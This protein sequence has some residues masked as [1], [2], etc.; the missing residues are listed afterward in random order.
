VLTASGLCKTFGSLRVA[1]DITIEVP[2]GRR[3]AIIGPNGAGKTTFFNLLAG[4]VKA[5]AG[6]VVIDGI[7]VSGAPPDAR[8]RAG[9]GRSFQRSNLFPALSVRDNILM[10]LI[11]RHRLGHVAW[12]RLRRFAA[13]AEEAEEWAAR[14]GLT[15]NIDRPTGHLDHGSQRQLEIALALVLEPKVLL[16]DE[17]TAGMSAQETATMQALIADLPAA[18]TILIVEHDME[19]VFGFAERIT[20]LDYGRVLLEGA[21]DE[22]RGSALVRERY[23]GGASP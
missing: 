21:P 4:E 1:D 7:D 8:A 16:L 20:V 13:L 15:G 12:R 17:P 10:A 14:V 19:V 2:Q 18:L 9:L 22:V 6:R 5:D 3:H 23:L 11:V